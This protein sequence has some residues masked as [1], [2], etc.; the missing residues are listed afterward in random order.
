MIPWKNWIK[1]WKSCNNM[2]LEG[3]KRI[4]VVVNV[5]RFSIDDF[6][7]NVVNYMLMLAYSNDQ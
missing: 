4:L 3:R 5:E 1:R 7:K 6:L 2:I